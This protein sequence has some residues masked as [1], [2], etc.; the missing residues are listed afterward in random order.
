MIFLG[1]G[2][3]RALKSFGTTLLRKFGTERMEDYTR[4]WLGFSTDNGAYYYYGWHTGHANG[5]DYQVTPNTTHAVF[6]PFSIV[7]HHSIM[8]FV[9]G[10]VPGCS[11][12]GA[13]V[14]AG[15]EDPVQA[16]AARLLVVHK[17][18][19]VS[20]PPPHASF[21]MFI[22]NQPKFV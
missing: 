4:Q 3:N 22:T 20:P 1:Q 8:S 19:R 7:V 16:R 14:L 10:V 21:I 12:G 15:R 9:I 6:D 17:G 18:R 2:V 5:N 13:R 11:D